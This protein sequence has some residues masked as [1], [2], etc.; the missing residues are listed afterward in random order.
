MPA[1]SPP[2][3]E[4]SRFTVTNAL[5]VVNLLVFFWQSRHGVFW[6]NQFDH[7]YA[8]SLEGVQHG[9]WWQFLTYQ[10]LHGGLQYPLTNPLA[11]IHIGCNMLFLHS[12]GPVL[13][14]T[15]GPRRFLALFLGSGIFGGS[16]HLLG[17]WMAP[18]HFNSP[19]VGAS[20]GLCGL[21]AALCAIYAEAPMEVRLLFII[22]LKMRAKFLLFFTA[23]ISIAGTVVP[24]G[25]IAHLAHLGGLV[26]GLLV[27]N[28]MTVKPL[29]L[30]PPSP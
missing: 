25:G 30:E 10:F 9:L 16:V 26:G 4:P 28:L 18:D 19:V 3:P 6:Q 8:L 2:P 13:E 23:S 15:L 12:L 17:A 5:I 29:Q 27:L 1:A 14:D 21:L 22:P 20:A 7:R 24:F 11:W